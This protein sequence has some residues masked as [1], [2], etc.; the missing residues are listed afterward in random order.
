MENILSELNVQNLSIKLTDEKI[1][2]NTPSASETFALRSLNGIGVIDLVE[3]YNDEMNQ[4]KVANS[5]KTMQTIKGIFLAISALVFLFFFIKIGIPIFALIVFAF[6]GG[7]SFYHFFLASK[8]PEKPTLVSAVRIMLNSGNRDF[9]FSKSSEI[10]DN[11]AQF[12]AKVESTLS[13]YHKSS[14]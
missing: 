1:Y 2:I 10:S 8:A 4:Y 9:E 3:K 11:V 13:A 6:F 12:V 14:N 7:F 5:K